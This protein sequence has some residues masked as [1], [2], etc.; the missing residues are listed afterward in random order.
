MSTELIRLTRRRG[1]D[2]AGKVN[3]THTHTH[4]RVREETTRHNTELGVSSPRKCVCVGWAYTPGR[5]PNSLATHLLVFLA[6]FIVFILSFV[7]VVPHLLFTAFFKVSASESTTDG[8]QHR[9]HVFLNLPG[10]LAVGRSVS[11]CVTVRKL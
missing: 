11:V 5:P 1:R 10:Q 6:L 3:Y 4:V 7:V 2:G 8:F 9:A